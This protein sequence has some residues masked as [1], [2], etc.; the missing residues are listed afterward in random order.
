MPTPNSW[1]LESPNRLAEAL[2][3]QGATPMEISELTPVLLQLRE[4]QAPTPAPLATQHLLATLRPALAPL[5]PV[6]T[7]I[8]ARHHSI[9][10]KIGWFVQI[11]SVQISLLRL[12]FWLLTALIALLGVLVIY[13]PFGYT[14]VF[15]LRVSSPFIIY[16][17]T[18][19]LFRSSR[20]HTLEYEL[21]CPPSAQQL[22]LA[23][24]IVLLGY[25]ML[26]GLGMSFLLWSHGGGDFLLLTLHWLA[27]LLLVAGIALVL[28][29]FISVSTATLLAYISWLGYA[30]LST[31]RFDPTRQTAL[32]PPNVQVEL[33][34]ALVGLV[35]LVLTVLSQ[36]AHTERFLPR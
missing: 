18:I 10:Q 12:S 7:A 28:S 20:L 22:V 31:I 36:A 2:Q 11:T 9:A 4:W 29:L 3:E 8:Q 17:G 5:S 14:S 16:L 21:A 24:L 25:D 35:A 26:L 19:R 30:A 6:R 27:P 33:V 32:A 34:L 1:P 23:R 13:S 15:L